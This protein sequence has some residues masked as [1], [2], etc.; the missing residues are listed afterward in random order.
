M[1]S[2][3]QSLPTS[4]GIAAAVGGAQAANASQHSQSL[5]E[6]RQETRIQTTFALNPYLRACGLVASVSEGCAILTGTVAEDASKDLA[7]QIAFGVQGIKSVDNRIE[8]VPMFVPPVSAGERAFGELVHDTTVTTAVR[9]KLAWSRFADG[10]NAGVATSKGRVTLTGTAPSTDTREAVGR[11]ALSTHGVE[12]IENQLEIRATDREGAKSIGAELADAWITLKVRST[13]LYSTHVSGREIEVH[14][15]AGV[16]TLKGGV[17][18]EAERALAVEL[19]G[20]VR[21]V[22]SVVST[23]LTLMN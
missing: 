19:A 17:D 15:Q 3:S 18:D 14:T 10:L 16:V 22:K 23:A 1:N 12:S 20:N 6:A 5:D 11:L 13:L 7:Q 4:A 9:S 8:V 2:Q 21:G